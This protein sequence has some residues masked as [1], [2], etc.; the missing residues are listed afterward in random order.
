MCNKCIQEWNVFGVYVECCWF[1]SV[2]HG[3]TGWDLNVLEIFLNI[4][5]PKYLWTSSYRI[6]LLLCT[7]KY[8]NLSSRHRTLNRVAVLRGAISNI[9]ITTDHRLNHD[10]TVW[11]NCMIRCQAL[12]KYSWTKFAT[13]V[14]SEGI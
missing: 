6:W 8:L 4:F 2:R 11:R 14:G 10:F 1:R 3:A 7:V 13:A 5:T 9:I 12:N